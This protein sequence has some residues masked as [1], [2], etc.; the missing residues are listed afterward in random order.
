MIF[1][2][3]CF[4]AFG[5][6]VTKYA[7]SASRSVIDTSRTVL[8]WFFFLFYTGA[9]HEKFQW[10]QLAGFVILVFGALIYNEILVIPILGFNMYTKAAIAERNG[11]KSS[12]SLL[13][14]DALNES[15]EDGYPTKP[16]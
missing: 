2:I 9:G 1:S 4:N 11:D 15:E 6:S 3:S 7:S 16:E 8:I 14:R 13:D 12:D 5:V 10:L